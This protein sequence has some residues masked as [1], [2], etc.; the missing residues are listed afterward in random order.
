MATVIR[1]S[2]FIGANR[3]EPIERCRLKVAKRTT[4]RPTKGQSDHGIPLFLAQL[5]EELNRGPSQT[6]PISKAAMQHGHDLLLQGFTVSE[7]VHDYSL[8]RRRSSS[9]HPTVATVPTCELF[10]VPNRPS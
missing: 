3:D 5:C 2:D 10:G 6:E 7:V 4:R 1:L 8:S 9:R